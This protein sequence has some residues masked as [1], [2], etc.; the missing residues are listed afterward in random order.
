MKIE[1]VILFFP[2]VSMA[3]LSLLVMG[4]GAKAGAPAQAMTT[5]APAK[6]QTKAASPMAGG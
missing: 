3:V 1:R 5:G 6:A 4:H 2:A